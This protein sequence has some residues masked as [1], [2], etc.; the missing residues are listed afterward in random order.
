MFWD[1]E[2]HFSGNEPKHP[3]SILLNNPEYK[4][5]G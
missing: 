2:G 1:S 5:Q 3:K 4:M